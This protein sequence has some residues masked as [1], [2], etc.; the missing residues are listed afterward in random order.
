MAKFEDETAE[1]VTGE[2]P[3]AASRRKRRRFLRRA[4]VGFGALLLALLAYGWI[5]REE[6]AD[7]PARPNL[8]MER[9]EVAIGVKWG[10]P[11][12]SRLRLVRP[13][14]HGTYHNGT[15]SFGALDPL[16][17]TESEEP[18]R[19]PDMDLTLIDGR[20]MLESDFGAIG[21]KAEGRGNLEDGFSGIFAVSAPRLAGKGCEAI[22]TTLFGKISVADGRPVLMGPLRLASLTCAED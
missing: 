16:I 17:F 11:G 4:L 22:K 21:A 20:G 13:R 18:P 19:L 5:Q 10:L 7:N 12:I 1:S 6:I 15:L 9:A 3:E 14:L 8:T 2:N